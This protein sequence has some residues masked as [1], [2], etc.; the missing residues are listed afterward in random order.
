[1]WLFL[2]SEFGSASIDFVVK[3]CQVKNEF[4]SEHYILNAC[5]AKKSESNSKNCQ[6]KNQIFQRKGFKLM[7][8]RQGF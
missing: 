5:K 1:M 3:F 4:Y 8:A 2:K 6:N 7:P